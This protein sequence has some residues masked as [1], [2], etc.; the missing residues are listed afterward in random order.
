MNRLEDISRIFAANTKKDTIVSII[1]IIAISYGLFYYWQNNTEKDIRNS[2]YQQQEQRQIESTE[3]LSR[4][5]GS[6]LGSIMSK[7]EVLANSATLQQGML[8]G[9]RTIDLLDKSYRQ[10]NSITP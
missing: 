1:L 6:D 4:H 5:I 7:L 9:N 2:L 10:I 3:A 8:V